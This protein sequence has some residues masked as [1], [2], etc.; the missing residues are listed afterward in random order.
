MNILLNVIVDGV[1]LQA[2]AKSPAIISVRLSSAM[3]NR[4]RIII[5]SKVDAEETKKL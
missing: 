3:N 5:L 2:N 4:V 1:P